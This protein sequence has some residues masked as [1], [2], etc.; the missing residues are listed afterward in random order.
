LKENARK[1]KLELYIYSMVVVG[2]GG[3]YI[4]IA[5]P[6]NQFDDLIILLR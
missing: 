1:N 6:S 3:H 5:R 2:N 4:D